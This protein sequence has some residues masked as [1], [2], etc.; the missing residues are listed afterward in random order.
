MLPSSSIPM[1]PRSLPEAS[2]KIIPVPG[3]RRSKVFPSSTGFGTD[4]SYRVHNRQT[5]RFEVF[6]RCL[7]L[8][9]SDQQKYGDQHQHTSEKAALFPFQVL[10]AFVQT[11][12]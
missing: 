4:Y 9:P 3:L 11:L 2:L 5:M 10:G 12:R 1:P 7:N 6:L 8:S